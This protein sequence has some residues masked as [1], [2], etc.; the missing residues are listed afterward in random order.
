M[1]TAR[2]ASAKAPLRQQAACSPENVTS[3]VLLPNDDPEIVASP[4]TVRVLLMVPPEIVKPVA[5]DVGIN[6]LILVAVAT[7]SIGVV[8]VGV[9][10]KTADPVPVSSVS[11][12]ANCNE[13]TLPACVPYNVPLVGKVT[14]V[15]AVEVSVVENAP[16]VVKSP[17]VFILPPSVIVLP[18]LA[19]PVPPFDQ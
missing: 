1:A 19:T 18:V 9:L 17:A 5:C 6:P 3:P 8:K 7:P 10:A 2:P 11:V 15:A 12:V 16:T 13:V 14:L 4:I